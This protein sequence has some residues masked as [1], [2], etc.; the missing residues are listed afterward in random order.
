MFLSLQ[1]SAVVTV[2]GIKENSTIENNNGLLP[3][4]LSLNVLQ[5]YGDVDIIY[6]IVFLPRLDT[7]DTFLN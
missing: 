6:I 5:I 2:D 1:L 7:F 3:G 4:D